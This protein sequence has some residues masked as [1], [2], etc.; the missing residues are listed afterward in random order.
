MWETFGRAPCAS[1]PLRNWPMATKDWTTQVKTAANEITSALDADVAIYNGRLARDEDTKVIQAFRSRR[2]RS[3][4]LLVLVTAGG[5]PNAAYRIGRYLQGAYARLT[6]LVSGECKSA[7][8]LI[9]LAAHEL[10]VSDLGE[11]GPLD[12]QIDKKGELWELQSGLTVTAALSSLQEKAFLA[13]EHFLTECRVRRLPTQTSADVAVKLTSGLLSGIYS[14]IDPLHVGEAA[15]SISI[16][17]RYGTRLLEKSKN[18][19][20]DA[21]TRLISDYPTH[22]FVIDRRE[23]SE[24][25]N[26]VRE[27][28]VAEETFCQLMG[29]VSH[30]EISSDAPFFWIPS[31]EPPV[32]PITPTGAIGKADGETHGDESSHAMAGG[33]SGAGQAPAQTAGPAERARTLSSAAPITVP[34]D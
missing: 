16:T 9:A 34:L 3:N 1:K 4:V 13:F 12:V 7:G 24:L 31:T 33:D 20:Q 25:F 2:R 26:A 11:L 15:R 5:D 8:T 17:A 6:V 29:A 14:Q 23:A 28:S 30:R 19:N 18:L 32:E 10:V 21:L 22:G 27:P